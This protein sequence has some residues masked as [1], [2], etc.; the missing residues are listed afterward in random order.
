V[1]VTPGSS[2]LH[3][4]ANKGD[5]FPALHRVGLLDKPF[6][7]TMPWGSHCLTSLRMVCATWL[8]VPLGLWIVSLVH[9]SPQE[10]C[11]PLTPMPRKLS[12]PASESVSG[13]LSQPPRG[14]LH[15]GDGTA[16]MLPAYE[17]LVL[18]PAGAGLGGRF[19]SWVKI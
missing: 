4:T 7:P 5:V 1:G 18:D 12:W 3:K 14:S 10:C 6:L 2:Q 11:H 19:M 13:P 16:P 17:A 9:V 8:E 15:G